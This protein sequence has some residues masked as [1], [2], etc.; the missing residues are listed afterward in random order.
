MRFGG[1]EEKQ[2]MI[3]PYVRRAIRTL[4]SSQYKA[5]IIG[6]L[7]CLLIALI[8]IC[9]S[10][11]PLCIG[12]A[13]TLGVANIVLAIAQQT[14]DLITKD[15]LEPIGMRVEHVVKKVI[16]FVDNV[17]GVILLLLGIHLATIGD[18]LPG[19][20]MTVAGVLSIIMMVVGALFGSSKNALGAS[21]MD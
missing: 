19:I 9:H 11:N 5:D 20:M 7:W 1:L 13:V 2:T 6:G 21:S 3:N 12:V 18:W 14:N 8:A 4:G 17:L 15:G 10:A 16:L